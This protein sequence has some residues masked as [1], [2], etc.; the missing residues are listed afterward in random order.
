MQMIL[1]EA[2]LTEDDRIVGAPGWVKSTKFNIQAKVDAAEAP[3]LEHLT[4]DQRRSMLV[5]LLVDRFN[6]KY[7]HETREIPV[8]SL[9]IAKGGV[10]MK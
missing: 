10:R 8:Y 5:P 1:R 6:L 2:F 7:H 9:V 4:I 3:K